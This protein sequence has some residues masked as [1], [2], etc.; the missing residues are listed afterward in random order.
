M[1]LQATLEKTYR[2]TAMR[3][4]GP[5]YRKEKMNTTADVQNLKQ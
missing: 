4:H 1:A 2:W 5:A 3:R